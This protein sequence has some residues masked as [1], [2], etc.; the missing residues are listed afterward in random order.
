M[1][2]DE[3][4]ESVETL[5][6]VE[7][8]R[9]IQEVSQALQRELAPAKKA[10]PRAESSRGDIWTRAAEESRRA[11][12]EAAR[13]VEPEPEPE[14]ERPRRPVWPPPSASRGAEARPS[15]ASREEPE[16]ERPRRPAPTTDGPMTVV[17][18]A[19]NA[20][21]GLGR[22][23]REA[24]LTLYRRLTSKTNPITANDDQG[25]SVSD[26]INADPCLSRG[27]RET[28]LMLYSQLGHKGK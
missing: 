20:D 16:P 14:P 10:E 11:E 24:L 6:A 2:L 26:A 9:L 19:L 7:K 4:L 3:I 12:R 18:H 28:L 25:M 22:G 23:Q 27:Q 21:S 5:S 8:L 15:R 13:A 1:T 17:V